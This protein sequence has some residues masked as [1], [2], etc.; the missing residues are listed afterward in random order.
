MDTRDLRAYSMGFVVDEVAVEYSCFRL[1]VVFTPK[2]RAHI[3]V[4]AGYDGPYQ[5]VPCYN[6]GSRLG[7]QLQSGRSQ[8]NISEIRGL[9]IVLYNF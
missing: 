4:L 2:L 1:L 3:N 6:I 8:L 9:V 5:L 7:L